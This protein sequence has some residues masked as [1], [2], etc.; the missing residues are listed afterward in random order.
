MSATR[1]KVSRKR[2]T[3]PLQTSGKTASINRGNQYFGRNKL[4]LVVVVGAIAAIIIAV[5]V[6]HLVKS[7]N[8]Q[9]RFHWADQRI[10]YAQS[11]FGKVTGLKVSSKWNNSCANTSEALFTSSFTCTTELDA[12]YSVNSFTE[13]MRDQTAIDKLVS[14]PQVFGG[15]ITGLASNMEPATAPDNATQFNVPTK[16]LSCD[17]NFS[18]DSQ[19]ATE[20]KL[21]KNG[22]P[23]DITFSISCQAQT[24]GSV[25]FN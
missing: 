12:T 8:D 5:V 25:S 6:G 23:T 18:P 24:A 15:F 22:S 4:T 16:S 2:A 20:S 17:W 7:F 21:I 13:A 3:K 1:N 14:S 11:Q 10:S 9:R 19:N